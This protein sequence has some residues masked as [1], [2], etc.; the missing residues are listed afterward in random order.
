MVAKPVHIF[1]DRK[2]L[3]G[4]TGLTLKRSK[5]QLTGQL[6][7]DVFMGW[8]P[9]APVLEEVTRGQEVLVYIGG[10]LAFTGKIDRRKDTGVKKARDSRGRFTGGN[11]GSGSS[12][13]IGADSYTVKMSCR[14]KTSA[15]I[16]S[17][18]QN[19]TTVLRPSNK[20][21]FD[22][23]LRPWGLEV[24]WEADEIELH[25]HR[26]RDGARVVDEIQRLAEMTSLYVFESREGT[27]KVTDGPPEASGEP[28]SLGTNI[29]SF[30]TDQAADTERS[31]VLV[32][33][34]LTRPEQWGEAAVVPT[35]QRVADEATKLFSP[36]TVQHYGEATDELL[37]RRANYE[38]NKRASESKRITV[39]VFHVQQ[40]DGAPW[41]IGV[42]HYVEIPPAG[43]FGEF[44]V[45]ELTYH[46]S[47]DKTLK[48]TLTLAPPPVKPKPKATGA[49]SSLPDSNPDIA[50][51]R[52][53][54]YDVSGN[55]ADSWQGPRLVG[56]EAANTKAQS[57]I[58][59]TI[60]RS[61]SRAPT[62]LPPS[63]TGAA[64]PQ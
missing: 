44:E 11:T 18:H 34:Q 52:K 54:K 51:T 40:T 19:P 62:S 26:L 42:K 61:R 53:G 13:S 27:L 48:T 32:K 43:V 22:D 41:D 29:L 6:D 58:L 59:D 16:D 64:G 4:C 12:L 36:I 20:G 57:K 31:E 60:E 30:S 47:N 21:L 63:F 45:V 17:S 10:H 3:I 24:E 38:A 1:I 8:L 23:F 46:I 2:E 7:I 37:E 9:E 5:N 25:R 50:N 56:K 33:G 49:L 35:L 15:L 55:F 14:G 28:I 39:E